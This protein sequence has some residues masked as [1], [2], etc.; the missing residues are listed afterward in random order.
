MELK[1]SKKYGGHL[2]DDI[3]GNPRKFSN[4]NKDLNKRKKWTR[5]INTFNIDNIDLV[6]AARNYKF[7]P[8]GT[9]DTYYEVLVSAV[10]NQ[11]GLQKHPV[12]AKEETKSLLPPEED[13][14][15]S[16]ARNPLNFKINITYE[17]LRELQTD[18]VDGL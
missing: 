5:A 16:C 6:V 2:D 15:E 7:A 9:V 10:S 18:L 8:S 3:K 11:T 12:R 1:N 14:G 13:L 4:L 17:T